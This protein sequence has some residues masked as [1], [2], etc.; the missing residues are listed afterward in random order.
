M[1]RENT[2]HLVLFLM[3]T[4]LIALGLCMCLGTGGSLE[5]PGLA[6]SALGVLIVCKPCFAM[7]V[8]AGLLPPAQWMSRCGD[9]FGW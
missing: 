2:M 6:A 9:V 5:I 3:G 4:L 7:A 8:K 1:K